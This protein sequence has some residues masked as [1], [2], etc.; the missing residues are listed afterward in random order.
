MPSGYR[1]RTPPSGAAAIPFTWTM[2]NI[3]KMRRQFRTMGAMFSWDTEVVTAD[4]EF[5][6]WNQWLFLR[7][8]SRAWPTA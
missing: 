1:P 6:R 2:T 8:L 5:Y 7:F 4:P 3:E